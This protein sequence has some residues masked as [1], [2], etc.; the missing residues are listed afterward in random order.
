MEKEFQELV[1]KYEKLK[2]NWNEWGE[3][4]EMRNLREKIY[5]LNWVGACDY[6]GDYDDLPF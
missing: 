5:R 4:L 2:E 6:F 1:N 3:S